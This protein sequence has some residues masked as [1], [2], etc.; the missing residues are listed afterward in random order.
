[1]VFLMRAPMS[2]RKLARST[3]SG[4]R[5][6]FSIT[7]VPFASTAAIRTLSVVVWLGYSKTTRL[8][9]SRPRATALFGTVPSMYPWT[10]SKDAPMAD[11]VFK[12][13]S[14][15]RIPKSSPPGRETRAKPLR[16][17]I[18]PST[19]IDAARSFSTSSYGASGTRSAGVSMTKSPRACPTG[20][21]EPLDTHTGGCEQVRHDLD[22]EDP[23]HTRLTRAG[24]PPEGRRP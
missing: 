13:M 23:R 3:T 4:S 16:A 5:A 14:T 9:T 10:V 21:L 1:M 2:F 8:P 17:S 12:W 22:V 15:G 20:T 6:A 18:G 7:V 19:T 24:L 11:N